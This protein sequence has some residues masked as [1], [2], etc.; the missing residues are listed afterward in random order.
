MVHVHE[1]VT[2]RVSP[3][4]SDDE[5]VEALRNGVDSAWSL[6]LSR[7]SSLISAAARSYARVCPS[8]ESF[9]TQED[10]SSGLYLCMVERLRDSI[11]NYYRG[12]CQLKTWIFRLIG[13]RRQI[14]KALLM[15]TE[16]GRHRA[17][18]RLPRTIQRRCEIDQDVYRR[19]VWGKDSSWIA[20]DL[21]LTEMDAHERSADIMALLMNESPRVFRRIMANRTALQPSVSLDRPIVNDDGDL[22][23]MEARDGGPLPDALAEQR[24]LLA[25]LPAAEKAIRTSLAETDE[26]D[27]RLLLL[28]FDHGWSLSEIVEKADLMALENVAARHQV[29]YRISRVLRA[30]AVRLCEYLSDDGAPA[31][32]DCRENV[33]SALKGLFREHGIG[34]FLPEARHADA[35]SV[36]VEGASAVA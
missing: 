30:M 5:L 16:K 9:E 1:Q 32:A 18:T 17:D 2:Y 19:L 10:T 3:D 7:Y 36:G 27:I 26:Q 35:E 8:Q 13:D 33:V 15:K 11:I 24:F 20:W 6:I 23:R 29:D 31:A 4:S 12:E 14:V 25:R 21:G 28:V 22:M 34:A